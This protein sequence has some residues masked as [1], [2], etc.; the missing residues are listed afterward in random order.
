MS[1]ILSFFLQ[2][3]P[4]TL[5]QKG[6]VCT[7]A[8]SCQE[9]FKVLSSYKNSNFILFW[10]IQGHKK[11][12]EQGHVLAQND[13]NKIFWPKTTQIY[14]YHSSSKLPFAFQNSVLLE[15]NQFLRG[16]MVLY[17][18]IWTQTVFYA[19]SESSSLR[20]SF[21]TSFLA[22]SPVWTYFL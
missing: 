3:S 18:I 20:L 11:I 12:C 19:K 17:Y 7:I 8:P 13:P 22:T 1:S 5:K 6:M 2:F 4:T 16:E 14:A 21:S 15:K 9:L 10:I